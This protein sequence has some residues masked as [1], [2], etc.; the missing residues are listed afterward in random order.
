MPCQRKHTN[1]HDPAGGV[2]CRTNPP[3]PPSKK[4]KKIPFP[5]FFPRLGDSA[6]LK[7][8]PPTP[9]PSKR[10]PPPAAA[11][12]SRATIDLLSIIST[13]SPR[14]D[15]STASR[16]CSGV[17]RAQPENAEERGRRG[18]NRHQQSDRRPQRTGVCAAGGVNEVVRV[19]GHEGGPC[20]ERRR[21]RG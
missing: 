2:D 1:H 19:A 18:G 14:I 4:K 16:A 7:N 8:V 21:G 9:F 10:K 15:S 20:G 12:A 11:T 6:S 5:R 13:T 3:P 17:V